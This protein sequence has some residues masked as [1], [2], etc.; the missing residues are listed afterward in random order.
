M[1]NR[2][3]ELILSEANHVRLAKK[4]GISYQTL[5]KL[6][7]GDQVTKS[8]E[9]LVDYY[10]DHKIINNLGLINVLCDYKKNNRLTFKQL[11]EQTGISPRT[12]YDIITKKNT[13]SD[14]V[15][16]LIEQFLK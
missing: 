7:N 9:L 16:K 11:S 3:K 2:S 1:Y 12:L 4:I 6:L 10:L 15:Y 13:P 5:K 8:I 14:R